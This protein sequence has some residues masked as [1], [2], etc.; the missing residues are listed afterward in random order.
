MD[1]TSIETLREKFLIWSG[2]SRVKKLSRR[3]IVPYENLYVWIN[4][5]HS[6]HPPPLE[7]ETPAVSKGSLFL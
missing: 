6:E 4:I 3:I 7:Q 1:E 2:S 5:P